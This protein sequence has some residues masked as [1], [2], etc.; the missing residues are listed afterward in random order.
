MKLF[1]K[2]SQ[3]VS[4]VM[5]YLDETLD[6]LKED[7]L[8]ST[9]IWNKENSSEMIFGVIKKHFN[10]GDYSLLVNKEFFLGLMEMFSL[11]YNETKEYIKSWVSK[12]LD[13][14]PN[15]VLVV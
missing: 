11:K 4:L 2:E 13:L 14:Q 8:E 3:F 6:G 5:N 9:F 1:L 7:S 10:R 15:D 12:N